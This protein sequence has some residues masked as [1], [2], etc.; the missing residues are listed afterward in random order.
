[1]GVTWIGM[2]IFPDASFHLVL[3]ACA[4]TPPFVTARA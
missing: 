3:R 4:Q 2:V 1:M